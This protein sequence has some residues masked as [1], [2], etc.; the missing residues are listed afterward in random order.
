MHLSR[1]QKLMK[2]FNE[3][4]DKFKLGDDIIFFIYEKYKD[5]SEERQFHSNLIYNTNFDDYNYIDEYRSYL[6]IQI[7]IYGNDNYLMVPVFYM[8]D[9]VEMITFK[10]P[11]RKDKIEYLNKTSKEVILGDYY[12]FIYKCNNDIIIPVR[13]EYIESLINILE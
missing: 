13:Q 3:I 10:K 7:K 12:E 2:V 1:H 11:N 8:A 5:D 4:G 6:M 9:G